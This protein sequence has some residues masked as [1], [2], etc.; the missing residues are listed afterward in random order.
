MPIPELI[1]SIRGLACL[2]G[3]GIAAPLFLILLYL[4]FW[5]PEIG[6]WVLK[7]SFFIVLLT[8]LLTA[9]LIVPCHFDLTF[10]PTLPRW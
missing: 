6:R 3:Y 4:W 8:A 9:A 7:P 2:T 10:Q 1:D 5:P